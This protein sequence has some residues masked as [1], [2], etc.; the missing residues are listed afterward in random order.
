MC[1]LLLWVSSTVMCF[2]SSCL[3]NHSAS[4]LKITP[5]PLIHPSLNFSPVTWAHQF[6]LGTRACLLAQASGA[7]CHCP[8]AAPPASRL[9]QAS[10]FSRGSLAIAG[11]PWWGLSGA[12][13][14]EGKK[15]WRTKCWEIHDVKHTEENQ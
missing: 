6:P 14:Y 13:N 8:P 12:G 9:V 15:P 2:L 11:D 10:C 3:L 5:Y 4:P 1:S 7:P